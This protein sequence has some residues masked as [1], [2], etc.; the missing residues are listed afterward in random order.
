MKEGWLLYDADGAKRNDW[1]IGR[2]IS[3]SPEFGLRLTLKILPCDCPSDGDFALVRAISPQ[4]NRRLEERGVRVFNNCRT[5]EIAN[6]KWK[7]YLF[8]QENDIAAL[9]TEVRAKEE[10]P[11]LP[12]PLVVKSPNGHG[13]TEVFWVNE[14]RVL[15]RAVGQM[16]A[17]RYVAQRPCSDPGKDLRIYVL[18]GKIYASVLRT[19]TGGFKSNYSLGGQARLFSP[20]EEVRQTVAKIGSLLSPDFVGMDFMPDNGR[21]VLNEIE[22]AVGCRMLYAL[23]DR[24]PAKDYLR[25]ISEQVN[26]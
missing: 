22:D 15:K 16:Q 19:S 12:Y 17:T 14:E 24:D 11:S 21:W 23:T 10:L 25:Y 20:P 1:F 18:G 8:C 2:L 26:R 4:T 6:D 13:G 9:P 5:S 3:L 7:T